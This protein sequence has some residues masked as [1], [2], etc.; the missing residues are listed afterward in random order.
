MAGKPSGRI[1]PPGSR[2]NAK[3]AENDGADQY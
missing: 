1:G 3:S 2:C